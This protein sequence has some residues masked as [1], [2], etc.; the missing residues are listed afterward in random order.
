MSS[1]PLFASTSYRRYPSLF[2]CDIADMSVL[3][4]SDCFVF[5]MPA[6]AV[7]AMGLRKI[8]SGSRHSFEHQISYVVSS[9]HMNNQPHEDSQKMK[10]VAWAG[11]VISTVQFLEWIVRIV[12]VLGSDNSSKYLLTVSLYLMLTCVL[13]APSCLLLVSRYP[14]ERISSQERR[15]SSRFLPQD[16]FC[17]SPHMADV[18]SLP[19]SPKVNLCPADL[20]LHGDQYRRCAKHTHDC[21]D[22]PPG[23]DRPDTPRGQNMPTIRPRRD[24]PNSPFALCHPDRRHLKMTPVELRLV[25]TPAGR[26]LTSTPGPLRQGATSTPLGRDLQNTPH[27]WGPSNTLPGRDLRN[28]PPVHDLENSQLELDL[29][30]ASFE[31]NLKNITS[32]VTVPADSLSPRT[33]PDLALKRNSVSCQFSVGR[34]IR[35]EQR[36]TSSAWPRVQ[37]NMM[38]KSCPYASE[39]SEETGTCHLE[40]A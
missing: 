16:N 38:S 37:N 22:T 39:D 29:Q 35:N 19:S 4:T 30:N 13:C 28:T 25:H 40:D 20:R 2:A 14:V 34:W 36:R 17:F 18:L 21:P 23:C 6:L 32:E 7:L 11:V 27:E 1:L 15:E 26:V 24:P 8:T 3:V 5:C 9:G 33:T 31:T 12:A 10:R